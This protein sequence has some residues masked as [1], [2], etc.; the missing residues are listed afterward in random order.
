MRCFTV[1]LD[2][3]KAANRERSVADQKVQLKTAQVQMSSQ[4]ATKMVAISVQDVDREVR[5]PALFMRACAST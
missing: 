4:G 1:F 5:V 2:R 3:H